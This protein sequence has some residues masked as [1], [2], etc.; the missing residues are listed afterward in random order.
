M[1]PA[2]KRPTHRCINRRLTGSGALYR[3]EFA[4]AD[5]RL[6]VLVDGPLILEADDMMLAA[7]LDGVGLAL[8]SEADAEPHIAAGRL[9]RALE[10]WCPPIPGFFLYHP[11]SRQG[12]ASLQALVEV[13]TRLLHSG[14]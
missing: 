6:A 11:R 8:V 9:V 7:A 4:K 3:W 10:D 2:L 5:K 12:S 13:L 1:S 14:S